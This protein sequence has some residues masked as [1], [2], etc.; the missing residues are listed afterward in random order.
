VGGA[1]E[2]EAVEALRGRAYA[3]INFGLEVLGKRPDGYHELRTILATVDFF[4]ELTFLSRPEGIQFSTNAPEL[5]GEDNLVCR[6]A[7]LLA[8]EASCRRG[9]TIHLEKRIPAGA[10]L[11]GGSSDAALTLLALDRLWRTNADPKDLHRL[12]CRL[13]MDVPFFLRG[14]T[15]IA[16]GR[17]DD[18]YPLD[19][20]LD[21][22]IVLIL[23]DFGIS[24]V[25]VYGNLRLTKRES[26]HTLQHFAWGVSPMQRSGLEDLVNDLEGATGARSTA[27]QEFK[28]LLREQGA[29]GSMMSGSGS[30]VFGVFQDEVSASRAAR[31]L[32]SSGIRAMATRTLDGT[33]YRARR[34]QPISPSPS[35]RDEDAERRG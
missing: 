28:R 2:E 18:L 33:T 27:I 10:G 35:E 23:P 30:S 7:R 20:P 15:A 24:T 29:R 19:L 31:A 3:K 14:G 1:G 25:E 12:A 13:G 17:G 8:E 16:V 6:A 9:A 11:G 4:D 32:G 26:S 21:F 5:Q 22:H 34:L